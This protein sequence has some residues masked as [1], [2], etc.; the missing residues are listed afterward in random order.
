MI[1]MIYQAHVSW[2]GSELR[3]RIQAQPS[4]TAGI[5]RIWGWYTVDHDLSVRHVSYGYPFGT[6]DE[7]AAQE[8][9]PYRYRSK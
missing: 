9:Q 3:R 1:C 2:V 7:R 8:P 6:H 4:T 5:Y